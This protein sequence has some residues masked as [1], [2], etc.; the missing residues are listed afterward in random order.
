MAPSVSLPADVSRHAFGS[1]DLDIAERD[2]GVLGREGERRRAPDAK[3]ASRDRD[4]PV[5]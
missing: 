5:L 4:H 3:R 1:G 2:H